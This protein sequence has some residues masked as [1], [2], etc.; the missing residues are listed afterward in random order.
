MSVLLSSGLERDLDQP[1]LRYHMVLPFICR[2]QS[3]IYI[4][5]CDV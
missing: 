3:P 1:V 5:V 4:Q 2:S